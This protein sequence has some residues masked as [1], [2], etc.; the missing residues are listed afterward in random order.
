MNCSASMFCIVTLEMLPL[1]SK[2]LFLQVED[3]IRSRIVSGDYPAHGKLPSTRE[4]AAITGTSLCTVQTAV[5]KLCREG[6]L[7]SQVGRGTYVIGDK[8]TLSCAGL[9]FRR[10]LSRAD[11]AFYQVLSQELRRKLAEAGVKVRVWSDERDENEFSGPPDSLSKAMEKREIQGLIAPLVSGP[12][13]DWLKKTPVP[14]AVVTTD[15]TMK[16]GVGGSFRQ[17]L[18]LGL[19]E[20]RR[21]GC[22]SVGIISSMLP[23]AEDPRSSEL[24][25]YRASADIAGEL[26]MKIHNEWILSP[27]EFTPHFAHFGHEQ[28]HALWDLPERPEGLLVYPDEVV[29]G[30]ITAVLER[31]VR[32]PQD[33]KVAFHVNDL[34]PYVCPF[35]AT[36]LCTEVGAIVDSLIELVQTQLAGNVASPVQVPVFVTRNPDPL[37]RTAVRSAV[38][39]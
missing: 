28:F 26:G 19:E 1:K 34:I 5:A 31:R 22:R 24:D 4:L 13:L 12:D 38:F 3:F 33:L 30:V 25:F 10:P 18:R 35:E 39:S 14:S 32:L 21:Q 36:F 2:P 37:R 9:Y 16:N 15:M 7:D 29:A 20:L 23:H 8:S 17:M 27:A 6:L 11:S